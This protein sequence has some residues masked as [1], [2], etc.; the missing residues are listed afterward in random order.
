MKNITYLLLFFISFGYSQTTIDF[1]PFDSYQLPKTKVYLNKTNDSIIATTNIDIE[2]VHIWSFEGDVFNR[3]DE[4][5]DY[6][7][8]NR[9]SIDATQFP[10]G[11]YIIIVK[12]I[13]EESINGATYID[14]RWVTTRFTVH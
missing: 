13:N 3:K 14:R 5:K 11:R 4:Y 12:V 8:L 2:S 10:I 9:I 1:E 7:N 6:E